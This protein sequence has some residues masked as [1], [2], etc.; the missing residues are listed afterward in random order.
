MPKRNERGR[1][2]V[3]NEG[4]ILGKQLLHQLI[5]RAAIDGAVLKQLKVSMANCQI[6]LNT[7]ALEVSILFAGIRDLLIPFCPEIQTV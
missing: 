2:V 3:H 1:A 7:S 4:P 6:S 5:E